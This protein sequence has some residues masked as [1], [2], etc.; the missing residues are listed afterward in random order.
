MAQFPSAASRETQRLIP[1]PNDIRSFERCRLD[2]SER[3]DNPVHT[4]HRDLIRLR[5]EDSRLN[6]QIRGRLDGAVLGSDC[7]VLRF[8][9]EQND[10]RLLVVNLGR[11]FEFNPCAEPLLA[12]PLNHKWEILWSSDSPKYGGPGVIEIDTDS[13]WMMSS[14]VALVMR[15]AV[16]TKPR[17]KPRKRE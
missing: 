11:R 14:D 17:P 15:P 9:A 4:L 12:P 5:R 8:F 16:R 7:F 3:T 1:K 13:S 2:W 10:D 6:Q